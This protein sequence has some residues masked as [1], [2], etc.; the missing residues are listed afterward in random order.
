MKRRIIESTIVVPKEGRCIGILVLIF[1][2]NSVV[3]LRALFI[4]HHY[5]F[6]VLD[7]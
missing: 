6:Y 4:Y 3:S 5:C 2:V 7:F 1:I